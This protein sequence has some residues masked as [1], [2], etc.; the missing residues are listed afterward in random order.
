MLENVPRTH[1]RFSDPRACWS[2]QS[3]GTFR[4]QGPPRTKGGSEVIMS[5]GA[6]GAETV[7]CVWGSG[8]LQ[9]GCEVGIDLSS[10]QSFFSGI[11]L[12][13]GGVEA[14]KNNRWTV[15]WTLVLAFYDSLEGNLSSF[16]F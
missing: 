6:K 3:T 5:K 9:L 2:H 8:D 10:A 14:G 15:R 4:C 16:P 12:V 7:S 1:A 13:T 11:P